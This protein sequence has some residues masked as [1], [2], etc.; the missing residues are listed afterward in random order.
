MSDEP[1]IA[2]LQQAASAEFDVP[3]RIMLSE[4]RSR[5]VAK[6]RQ[7]AMFLSVRLTS[8]SLPMIA[9]EFHRDHTTVLHAVEAI[10]RC[11]FEC[12]TYGQVAVN[13]MRRFSEDERQMA[14]GRM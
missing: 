11:I 1:T 4:R 7:V 6:A 14:L 3:L 9:R 5:N 12:N 8:R 2:E 10:E 13:L